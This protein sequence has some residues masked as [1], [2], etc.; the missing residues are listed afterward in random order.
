MYIYERTEKS[1]ALRQ[2]PGVGAAELG[3]ASGGVGSPDV[4]E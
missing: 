1:G 3:Y 4:S 2:S